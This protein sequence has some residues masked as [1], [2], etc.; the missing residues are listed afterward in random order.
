[1][2]D[3]LHASLVRAPDAPALVP[4]RYLLVNTLAVRED[5]RRSGV[6]RSLM[7]SAQSW[8]R[9]RGATEVELNVWG[10]NRGAIAF[11]EAL[12]YDTAQRRMRK[13]LVG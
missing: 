6:G 11:Y 7:V 13:A 9:G 1:M 10:F 8:G 4:R 3:V 5:R 12:G 2:A